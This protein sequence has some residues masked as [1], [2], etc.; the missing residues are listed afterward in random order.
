M[1]A[2]IRHLPL[3]LPDEMFN[4]TARI[5]ELIILEPPPLVGRA[6]SQILMA[7]GQRCW[8]RCEQAPPPAPPCPSLCSSRRPRASQGLTRTNLVLEAFANTVPHS[9]GHIKVNINVVLGM[10]KEPR[11]ADTLAHIGPVGPPE[12]FSQS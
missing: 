2:L 5:P 10:H 7:R 12:E 11:Q 3:N 1:A 6:P 8:L 4:L 9:T